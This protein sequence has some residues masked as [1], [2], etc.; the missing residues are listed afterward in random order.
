MPRDPLVLC[1]VLLTMLMLGLVAAWIPARK[2]LAVDP[3][4]LLREE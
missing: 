2:A 3:I 4:I 1:G